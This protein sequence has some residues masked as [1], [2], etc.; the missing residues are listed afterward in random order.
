[1]DYAM[2]RPKRREWYGDE[3]RSA[4]TKDLP[5]TT[6]CWTKVTMRAVARK[7]TAMVQMTKRQHYNVHLAKRR[8][9]RGGQ[10]LADTSFL[11]LSGCKALVLD[12][13]KGLQDMFLR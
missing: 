9:C 8:E 1:M 5:S 2:P 11:Q 7:K 6:R 12:G 10:S 13:T 4:T 3:R